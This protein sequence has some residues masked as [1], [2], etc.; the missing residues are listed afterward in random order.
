MFINNKYTSWYIS[1]IS[2]AQNRNLDRSFYTEKHHIIPKSLGG[3]DA[4]D[5]LVRLTGKEH[6]VA[7]LLLTKMTFGVN[8]RKMAFALW[9]MTQDNKKRDRFRMSS[10]QYQNI[11]TGM[12][13]AMKVHNKG[14]KLSPE[15]IQKVKDGI[16]AKGGAHNKGKSMSEDQ[17]HSRLLARGDWECSEETRQKISQG[18][19]RRATD[20]S[21]P[22]QKGIPRSRMTFVLQNSITQEQVET[23][24]LRQWCVSQGFSSGM[25]Y[26]N[27]SPWKIISKVPLHKGQL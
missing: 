20:R 4:K 8:A 2:N 10:R 13:E 3:N 19:K 17:K 22:Y 14:K 9:R 23:Y 16:A 24:N 1:L 25:I 5:N 18:V 27:K 21:K 6:F 15:H 7:H 11:K 26:L 12:S